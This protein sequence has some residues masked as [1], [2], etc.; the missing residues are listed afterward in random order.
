VVVSRATVEAIDCIGRKNHNAGGSV[1]PPAC[2]SLKFERL[3]K[4]LKKLNEIG[5]MN[6]C[7][8]TDGNNKTKN[9]AENANKRQKSANT[10]P[11][12]ILPAPDN[13]WPR[14]RA[15]N[16]SNQA[17]ISQTTPFLVSFLRKARRIAG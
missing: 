16:P 4:T 8:F 3:A 15:T 5:Q 11:P 6:L 14:R 13:A 7:E 12:L 9:T 2:I 1:N 17:R 10:S